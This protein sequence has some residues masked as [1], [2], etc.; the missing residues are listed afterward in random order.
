[1]K[2]IALIIGSLLAA[3]GLVAASSGADDKRTYEAELFNAFGLVEGSEVRISGVTGG[4]VTDLEITPEKTALVTF[5]IGPEFPEL[6]ADASCS[7]E[8]QSL[9]AEYFIDC[10]PGSSAEPLEEPIPADRN[11]TTVQNDLVNNTLREP[12]KRR[13]QLILNEFGT[14]L[15]G[16][17]ENLNDAIRAGAPALRELN[18]VL[19]I[20]ER[21]NTTIAQLNA[22]SDTVFAR[23]TERREDVVRFIDE[24]EDTARISSTRREDLAT[25]FDL[26]DDFL[27]ELQPTMVELGNLAREQTPLLVDLRAAAPGLNKLGRNLPRFNHASQVSL[28]ALGSASE[29]GERALA[30][31][32]DEIAALNTAGQ[33]AFPAVD[34]VAKFLES[35]DDPRNAVEEDCDA[36]YDLR[37]LP[38]EAD[39]RQA[40]LEQKIGSP[41]TGNRNANPGCT[42]GGGTPGA[43]NPGYTG[44]EGLLNYAY[45]QTGSLN[46]YDA[47]GHALQ[48]FIVGASNE[49]EGDG[50]CGHYAPGPTW[51]RAAMFGGGNTNNP[52][53]AAHCVAILGDYQPGISAGTV[54]D[55]PATEG[56]TQFIPGGGFAPGSPGLLRRYDGSVCPSTPL[57]STK[58]TICDPAIFNS[59]SSR[60]GP[61]SPPVAHEDAPPE[62]PS[63]QPPKPPTP[64]EVE[65]ALDELDEPVESVDELLE[66]LG[67]PPGTPLPSDVVEGVGLGA[68]ATTRTDNS[69][70]A[71]DFLNFLLGP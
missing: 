51:P 33:K 61:V 42:I 70:V 37:E 58:K 68:D 19:K 71:A 34:Q 55:N 12:F 67:L 25:D 43:G 16:N 17:E 15:V 35:I 21:Q 66:A 3:S 48:I 27:A 60:L 4:T 65:D 13:F 59:Y 7:S 45:V 62:Q 44:L 9:I 64:E 10:Q 57:G 5:E 63:D 11:K 29:V 18:E 6:K 41:L 39:R 36:R 28:N 32:E 47:A 31:S 1:M 20:L 2:R 23:L 69:E 30:K 52:R 54:S 38:G 40:L 14:A 56:L 50:Q 53:E 8:P 49:S 22:D 26:L 46:L 24:A